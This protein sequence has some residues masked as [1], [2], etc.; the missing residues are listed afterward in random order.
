[1][2]KCPHFGIRSSITAEN[3]PAMDIHREGAH[4]N[5]KWCCRRRAPPNAYS[6]GSFIRCLLL[7]L[8]R[9]SST[10]CILHGI[11]RQWMLL[12]MKRFLWGCFPRSAGSVAK[13]NQWIPAQFKCPAKVYFPWIT[14][15]PIA[16]II[17]SSCP[18]NTNT[19]QYFY[20]YFRDTP[21]HVKDS[22]IAQS[23][24]RTKTKE[25]NKFGR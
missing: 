4:Q 1:M 11:H 3:G 12:P 15:Q 6:F 19:V 17:N 22:S 18:K 7:L 24:P 20:R 13:L 2:S 16:I 8:L 10:F 5:F 14:H 23:W 9:S 25:A 21:C